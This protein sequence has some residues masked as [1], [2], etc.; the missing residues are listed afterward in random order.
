MNAIVAYFERTIYGMTEYFSADKTVVLLFAVFLYLWLREKKTAD[1]SGNRTL[2]YSLFMTLVL[3]FPITAMVVVIYQTAFYDYA[4]AWSLVPAGAVIAYGAVVFYRDMTQRALKFQKFL[5]VAIM[6]FVLFI[7]G[8]QGTLQMYASA[9]D[10]SQTKTIAEYAMQ[11]EAGGQAVLWAPQNLMQEMRRQTGKI[12]LIYGRDMWDEKA[13]AYDYEVY[14]EEFAEAYE[15]L[16]L[17][18]LLARE[19]EDE[20]LFAMLCEEYELEKEAYQHVAVMIENDVNVIAVSKRAAGIFAEV[21]VSVAEEK[22][23][24]VEEI[25]TEQYAVY[26]LK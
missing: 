14:S 25:Y 24:V 16:E 18:D 4:W 6:I 8:N 3:L 9:G 22:A 13:G 20:R 21:L 26:L 10:I 1:N 17:V 2:V 23:L 12:L 5:I 7:C 15:W 19:A 11:R